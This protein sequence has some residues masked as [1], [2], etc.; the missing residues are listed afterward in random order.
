MGADRS[1]FAAY[2]FT[3]PTC[4]AIISLE[5]CALNADFQHFIPIFNKISLLHGYPPKRGLDERRLKDRV[6]LQIILV[7]T[8]THPKTFTQ[9]RVSVFD[10]YLHWPQVSVK[11]H[12]H[13]NRIS[14]NVKKF[15]V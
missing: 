5:P 12:V 8:L 4:K 6:T 1:Q 15:D 11:V 13:C 7:F 14:V 9:D 10:K 2:I 3:A